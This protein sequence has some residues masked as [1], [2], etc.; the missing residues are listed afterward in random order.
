MASTVLEDFRTAIIE[1]IETA[2]PKLL[3]KVQCGAVDEGTVAPFATYSSPEEHPIR[4]KDGIAGCDILFEVE[5]FSNSVVQA[6]HL[7][8]CVRDAVE[9]LSFA[10]QTCKFRG[11]SSD[12]Y[13]DYDLHSWNLTFK[14]I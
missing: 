5:V 13:P 6:E 14:V 4:T 1:A 8:R 3:G 11:A 7:K 9:G 2:A 12:Y 10:G